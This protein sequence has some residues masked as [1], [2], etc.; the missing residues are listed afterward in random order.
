MLKMNRGILIAL[1]GTLLLTPDSLFMRWSALDGG[2]MLAWR[3]TLAGTVFILFGTAR[4]LLANK[5]SVVNI[6]K[7]NFWAL[8]VVQISNASFFSFA[9]AIAPVAVVL[10]AVATVPIISALLGH[11]LLKE[12]VSPQFY[13]TICLV[14]LGITLSVF[15]DYKSGSLISFS[16][17][18]GALFGLAVALSLALNFTIIRKDQSIPFEVALGTGG[19]I[20]GLSSFVIF[21]QALNLSLPSAFYISFTGIFILPI[22]FFLLSEASRLTSAANVSIIMLLETVLGPFWVWF[23]VNEKPSHFAL[24]GG[25]IVVTALVY[26]L[27]GEQ[28][29]ASPIKRN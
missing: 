8:V 17:L 6:F 23:G 21:P 2:V 13:V 20:A 14:F 15:G 11:L 26:F 24:I 5:R 29:S 25:V 4:L 18:L 27:L 3:A 19:L 12:S 9:I 10:I 1:A 22:S 16:T 28:R 7:F